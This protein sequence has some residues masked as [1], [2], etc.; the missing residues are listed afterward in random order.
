MWLKGLRRSFENSCDAQ[1][2]TVQAAGRISTSR[3][4]VVGLGAHSP[5]S[6]RVSRCPSI[7][8]RM[9]RS[10]SSR[11]APVVMQPGKSGTDAAQLFSAC[12]KMTAYRTLI[13][14]SPV[15]L[16]SEW[17]SA[18][19]W[20]DVVSR[21]TRDCDDVRP[22]RMLEVAMASRGANMLPSVRL[23][24]FHRSR[25]FAA[26]CSDHCGG[27]AICSRLLQARFR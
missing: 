4:T 1:F 22:G 2:A 5:Y 6:R 16:P 25:T 9:F 11:V 18:F 27:S 20:E 14:F 26:H 13:A 3:A 19:R 10:V 8:S 17:T 23:Y 12:S 7:A 24:H 21:A 15:P